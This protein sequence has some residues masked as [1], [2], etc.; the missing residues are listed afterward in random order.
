MIQD[1]RCSVYYFTVTGFLFEVT[2]DRMFYGRHIDSYAWEL[3]L[4]ILGSTIVILL[5]FPK[6]FKSS[7]NGPLQSLLGGMRA[8]N[9]GDKSVEVPVHT[10]D[11]FGFL[12]RSFNEMV[13]SIRVAGD[14]LKRYASEL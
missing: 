7:L 6:F 12:T 14:L 13:G 10:D 3:I 11:E 9:D 2:Y 8:V 5:L 4:F 1:L